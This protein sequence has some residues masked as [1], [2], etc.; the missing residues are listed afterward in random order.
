MDNK[1]QRLRFLE[2]FRPNDPQIA[3]LRLSLGISDAAPQVPAGGGVRAPG[4]PD[5]SNMRPTPRG[6][7]PSPQSDAPTLS[8]EAVDPANMPYN[9]QPNIT[10]RF[11]GVSEKGYLKPRGAPMGAMAVLSPEQIALKEA[12]KKAAQ[13]QAQAA[14][15]GA[16]K[17]G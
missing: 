12:Q 3:K 9:K 8:V 10:D 6:G 13:A 17:R 2:R 14:A 5:T 1:L 7:Q 11:M 4:M 16:L 15:S